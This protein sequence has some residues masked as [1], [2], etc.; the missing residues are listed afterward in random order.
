MMTLQSLE[1]QLQI[2]SGNFEKSIDIYFDLP[3]ALEVTDAIK[4]EWTAAGD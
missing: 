1:F 2:V 3:E 4:N